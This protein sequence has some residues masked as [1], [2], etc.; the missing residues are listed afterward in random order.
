MLRKFIIYLSENAFVR[1]I[2]MQ[3]E[4]ARRISRRFVA[5]ET[6]DEAVAVVKELNANGIKG[7][8]NEVG[9]SVTTK[10]EAIEASKISIAILHRIKAE[11]LD[12][13]LSVK[14]SHMG[15]KFGV[16]FCFET[17]AEIVK[18]A[19]GYNVTLE[20]DIEG[21]PDVP[22]T[23]ELYHRLLDTFGSG[24]IHQALQD[25]LHRN[26]S[27]STAIFERGG[28][29]RLVKGAYD[30]SPAIAWQDKEK[31]RQEAIE[32]MKVFL[33]PEIIAKGAYL[34]L[35]SHD[36]YLIDWL[37][38]ET[39]KLGIPRDQYEVQM[40]L[41]IRRDEQQN[42]A[43]QGIRSRVYVPYGTAW[44]PYFMRRMAERPANLWFIVSGFFRR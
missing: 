30:E 38:A 4:P 11:G 14:P 26:L 43:N 15:M 6:L 27:D 34:A 44:Y 37:V 31:I 24:S 25:Y 17:I 36:P 23:L 9:E 32:V 5:G 8:I 12:S 3:F 39:D 16:D 20:I 41:G 18:V 21:S 10:E 19:R 7:M 2:M 42:L 29:I 35:G 28:G 22:A 33:R 40:L 13:T 1:K